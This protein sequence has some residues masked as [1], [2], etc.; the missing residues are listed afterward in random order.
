VQSGGTRNPFLVREH[1]TQLSTSQLA[2]DAAASA[3]GVGK[4]YYYMEEDSS[5]CPAGVSVG[6]L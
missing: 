6:A 4:R 2:E 5:A 3:V 1:S